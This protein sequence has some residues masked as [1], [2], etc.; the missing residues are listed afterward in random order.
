MLN[1]ELQIGTADNDGIKY[2]AYSQLFRIL[3]YFFSLLFGAARTHFA[4]RQTRINQAAQLTA[5]S[6]SATSITYL[7][8]C[9]VIFFIR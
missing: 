1:G 5:R 7:S 3:N 2:G 9:S 4:A 8:G 6:S